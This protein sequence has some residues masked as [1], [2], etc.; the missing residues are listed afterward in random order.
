MIKSAQDLNWQ[1]LEIPVQTA[2][3]QSAG[4]VTNFRGLVN[5]LASMRRNITPEICIAIVEAKFQRS[6]P[7]TDGHAYIW[8][9]ARS[10][11]FSE[12]IPRLVTRRLAQVLQKQD[13]LWWTASGEQQEQEVQLQVHVQVQ[14]AVHRAMQGE[15]AL[16]AVQQMSSN[17]IKL[18]HEY[19]VA[20]PEEPLEQRVHKVVQCILQLSVAELSPEVERHLNEVRDNSEMR[21][22][23]YIMKKSKKKSGEASYARVWVT[24]HACTLHRAF[25]WQSLPEYKVYTTLRIESFNEPSMGEMDMQDVQVVLEGIRSISADELVIEIEPCSEHGPEETPPEDQDR[26]LEEARALNR[27]VSR[28]VVSSENRV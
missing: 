12:K 1:S 22:I 10:T 28:V 20:E 27:R 14:E 24:M 25:E 2:L 3:V 15:Q 17:C 21:Q 19:Q 16:L 9:D 7:S 13:G 26:L 18:M 8:V 6:L 4:N 23:P 5:R 11:H